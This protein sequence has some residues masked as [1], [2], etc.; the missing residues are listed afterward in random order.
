MRFHH[1]FLYI[2]TNPKKSVLY[3]GVTN[4]L[5]NRLIEHFNNRGT[6][7]SFAGKFFCYNLVYY[8]E[9]GNVLE[10]IA[11]EKEIKKWNRNKKIRLIEL[12]NPTFKIIPY[13]RVNTSSTPILLEEVNPSPYCTPMECPISSALDLIK[14]R[15]S[16]E[17]M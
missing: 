17:E 14:F 6:S 5:E 10:A 15:N 7:N 3:I 4:S 9:F 1:Y 16:G 2:T 11:R 12:K 8:E 13:F